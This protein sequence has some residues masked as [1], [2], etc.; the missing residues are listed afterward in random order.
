MDTNQGVDMN[1]NVDQPEYGIGELL[2]VA[3]ARAVPVVRALPDERLADPTP[4][5]DYDVKGLANHLLHVIVEFQKLAA[6]KDSD[7]TVTPDYIGTD[8]GW[9][10]RFAE[11][12][13]RLAAAWS[14][15]GAE[16]GTT[17]AMN[18]P[19]RIVGSMVLLDL[20]V[21][22]W[23]LARAT[24]QEYRADGD[25]EPVVEQLAGAVAEMAPTARAM[26]VFAEPVPVAEDASPFERLLAAT[27]RDP[28]WV[29]A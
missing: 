22:V 11:E 18:M 23:D 1:Q 4:C 7:F 28:H 2:A 12:T 20:I 16:D 8:T 21:H 19:A 3:G 26:G 5:T 15:P 17:G 14:A 27:G 10:E 13:G 6:K 24:G 29:R 25:A 9:R